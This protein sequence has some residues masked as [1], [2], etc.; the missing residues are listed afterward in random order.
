MHIARIESTVPRQ[1]DL[2]LF[3]DESYE[4]DTACRREEDKWPHPENEGR[5]GR[6]NSRS[7]LDSVC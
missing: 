4:L 3:E 7:M 5:L 2:T 6:S 1:Q